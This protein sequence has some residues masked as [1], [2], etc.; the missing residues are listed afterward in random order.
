[1]LDDI[2]GHQGEAIV[3]FRRLFADT[4]KKHTREDIDSLLYSGT[5]AADL[6]RHP[7]RL[8]W[9]YARVG[10]ILL[11]T[12]LILWLTF[13]A[14]S[15]TSNV[16]P[17]LIF[18]GA[19]V[20]PASLMIFFWES[21]QAR[22]ISLFDL[23]RIFFIGGALSILLTFVIG[24]IVPADVGDSVGAAAISGLAIGLTEELAKVLVVFALIRR[25]QGHLI[26]NGLLVGAAVGTGFAVF[27]TA[28]YGT[29]AWLAYGDMG[30]TLLLRGLLS[31]GGH[32]VWTGIAGAALML[33]QSTALPTPSLKGLAWS[34]FL[35]LFA[36]AIAL[37]AIWDFACFVVDDEYILDLSLVVL[38]VVAWIVVVRVI[39]SG[40]RQQVL[41]DQAR[42]LGP[43]ILSQPVPQGYGPA[44]GGS[45]PSATYGTGAPGP[46][47]P[48]SYGPPGPVPNPSAYGAGAPGSIPN[49]SPY[50]AGAPGGGLRG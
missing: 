19:L 4:F 28:G 29:N 41:V 11:A 49:P 2:T 9:L 14:F 12:F 16:I 15:G 6:D 31:V 32:V 44:A 22:N 5:A 43:P 26:L 8:P 27:E 38:I 21:N 3:T 10:A 30:E 13:E 48:S 33:A 18:T 37:H 40:L 47:S 39:N 42:V 25:L 36:V 35:P 34:R 50:G 45:V 46:I 23:I 17:G 24:E 20:V 7:Y 1:M